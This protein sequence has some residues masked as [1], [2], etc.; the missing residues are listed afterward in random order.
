MEIGFRGDPA[1]LVDDFVDP[2]LG[3]LRV[4]RQP[5]GR[6]A[7]GTKELLPEQFAGVDIEVLFHGLVIIGDFNFLG[8]LAIPSKTHPILVV[9]PDAVLAGPAALERFESVAR[10]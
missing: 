7:H 2:L 4:F 6:E 3:E 10:R 5:V 8:I 1:L 9:N